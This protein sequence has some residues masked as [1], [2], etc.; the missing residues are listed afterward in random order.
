MTIQLPLED[1]DLAPATETGSG[2]LAILP[3]LAYR[4][5][6]IVNV[7]FY[8]EPAMD[9]AWVLIDTGLATSGKA[10]IEAAEHRFGHARPPSAILMTH[11]HFDHAGALE[12]LARHW[13][14]PVYAHPLEFP[15]LRGE[16]SYPPADPLVGGGAMALLSPLY[17]RSPV[18]I[19][20]WLRALPADGSTPFMPG[21][22]WLHTPGHTPG[23][24]SF[25]RASDRCLIAG[26]AIIT[27]GQESVYEVLTQR[28]EM[29][30]PPRYMT[31]DWQEAMDSVVELAALEP[32]TIIAGHGRPM[33][34]PNVTARLHELAD[35]FAEIAIPT[36]MRPNNR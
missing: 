24:V 10:I 34:G 13:D 4:R 31:S 6:S 3:D 22:T 8:G 29:H 23:H 9:K 2:V 20:Q 15:Y 28:P 32:E 7:I 27:T 16:N 35:N 21:W 12:A 30:G 19:G 26:D 5:M 14:V 11:G 18:D 1:S 25:W 17:P 36:T 33:R